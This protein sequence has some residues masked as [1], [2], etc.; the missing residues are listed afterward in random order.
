MRDGQVQGVRDLDPAA[1]REARFRAVYDAAYPDLIRFASRRVDAAVAEDVVA[2]AFL[3]AWRRFD[4]L[5]GQ[6]DDARAWMFGIARGVILNTRRGAERQRALNVR[7]TEAAVDHIEPVDDHAARRVDV[8]RAWRLLSGRHQEALALA[9]L[10]GL[11]APQAAS[12]L[13]ISPVAFR[14]RLS[15]ARRALRVHLEHL[16]EPPSPLRVSEGITHEQPA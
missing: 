2:E 10:D 6:P 4:D 9:V 13:G 1:A 3:V 12:V 15:R 8:A 16:P 14:L 5:P 7:L 11:P